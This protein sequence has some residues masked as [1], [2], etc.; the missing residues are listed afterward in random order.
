MTSATSGLT[1]NAISFGL[2]FTNN[3][4]SAG[5]SAF[6]FASTSL[7]ASFRNQQTMTNGTFNTSSSRF[8]ATKRDLYLFSASAQFDTNGT[9]TIRGIGLSGTIGNVSFSTCPPNTV[10]APGVTISQPIIMNANYTMTFL[11]INDATGSI[12][13][14]IAISIVL[15][16]S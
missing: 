16:A 5:A 3:F 6:N 9:G 2:T 10:F 7:N 13:A 11:G 1:A 12:S 8:T 14:S 4:I 15:I